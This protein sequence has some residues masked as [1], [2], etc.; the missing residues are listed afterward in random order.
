MAVIELPKKHDECV[1]QSRCC[2]RV[3]ALPAGLERPSR[4]TL[5]W[6]NARTIYCYTGAYQLENDAMRM[7][8]VFDCNSEDVK[9]LTVIPFGDSF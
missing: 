3:P 5:E 4:R 6:L 7:V 8:A 2:H 9:A 1:R